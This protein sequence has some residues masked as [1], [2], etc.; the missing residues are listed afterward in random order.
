M[1]AKVN[2]YGLDGINGYKIE[3]ESDIHNGLPGWEM[4]GL[5]GASTKESKER[6]RSA[7]ANSGYGFSPKKITINMAP[8]DTKKDGPLY[9]LPIAMAIL[10]ATEQLQA[11]KLNDLIFIGELSLNGEVKRVR[12]ILPILIAAKSEGYDRVIIPDGNRNE[13]SYI[14]GINVYPVKNLRDA[15]MHVSG[16]K[17]IEPIFTHEIASARYKTEYADDFRY[18]MGQFAAKRAMEIA[19]AGGHNLLMIGPPGG[20]KTMLAKCLPSILPDMTPAEMLETTKIHSVAGSLDEERGIITTRPFRAPHHTVSRIALTGGGAN[21]HPGE[22]SLAHNGVLFLDELP[23][24]PRSVLEILRQP[25]EDKTIT[26]SRALR[27]VEYPAHFMLIA[28]MNPCPC[29]NY[30]SQTA[31]CTCTPSQIQKYLARLS[32]PLLDRIDLHI[33]VDN[34]KY[35]ELAGKG[36]SEDSATIRNRVNVAREI[37]V[38]RYEG[39]GVYCNASMTNKM[40]KDYCKLTSDGEQL[41]KTAFEKFGL[42][43]RAYGRVLKVARTI[44]DLSGE[45]NILAT[46]V[47]E[48]VQYRTLDRSYRK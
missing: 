48:A 46:H 14:E 11:D 22:V 1:L 33:G 23:E 8:A 15:V 9:D 31:D 39:T 42:S 6:V 35:D 32:A 47:A 40:V 26:V 21:A 30:G 12:G 45:E 16:E 44:A 29:G 2:S 43:A 18:V 28:S 38:K 19:A 10:A 3:V 5:P 13:A 25:L 4:V 34:V 17:L 7:I 24:Y 27:S 20:G 37:Q 36:Y 41:L